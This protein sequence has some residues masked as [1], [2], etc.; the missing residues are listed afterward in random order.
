MRPVFFDEDCKPTSRTAMTGGEKMW[1][2]E[3]HKG[4]LLLPDGNKLP[5]QV[6]S[7]AAPASGGAFFVMAAPSI[8]QAAG[9]HSAEF[10]LEQLMTAV[11][12]HEA[13]TCYSFQPTGAEL[14]GWSTFITFPTTSAT[15][16]YRNGLDLKAIS[17]SIVRETELLL[18]AAADRTD[19]MR[20]AAEARLLA[21]VRHDY[22]V[23]R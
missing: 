7:F 3:P 20:F 10:G 1:I 22:V 18:A 16:A 9:V 21:Q 23:F 14:P 5:A 15:T 2:A 6:V 12:I 8:W 19:A 13:L 11:M 4:E 17:S